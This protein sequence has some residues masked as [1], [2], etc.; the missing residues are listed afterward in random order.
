MFP[1]T[2]KGM[3]QEL[4][5]TAHPRNGATRIDALSVYSRVSLPL[6]VTLK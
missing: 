4:I 3:D 6:L 2:K 5:K 1:N